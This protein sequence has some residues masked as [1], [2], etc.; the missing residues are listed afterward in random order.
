MD[1][2]DRLISSHNINLSSLLID[3]IYM[4]SSLALLLVVFRLRE[5]HFQVYECGLTYAKKE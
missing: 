3:Q 4:T 1:W 2:L 5:S